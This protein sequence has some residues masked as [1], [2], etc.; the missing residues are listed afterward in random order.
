MAV[1]G[2]AV[3]SGLVASLSRPGGIIT[4]STFFPTDLAAK[5]IEL[6]RN[7]LPRVALVAVDKIIE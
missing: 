4:G 3:A 7:A 1:S 6:L 5:R 2:D